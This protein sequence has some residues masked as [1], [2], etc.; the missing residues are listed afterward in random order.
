MEFWLGFAMF[1][2]GVIIGV[3]FCAWVG[4]RYV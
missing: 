4:E 2:F 1:L 3:L